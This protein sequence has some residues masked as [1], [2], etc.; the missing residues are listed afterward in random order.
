MAFEY[1]KLSK[2]QDHLESEAT[3]WLE[4]YVQEFYKVNDFSE[5]TKEQID[6]IEKAADD[7]N[8]DYYVA[9]VLRNI[10]DDWNDENGESDLL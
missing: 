7:K 2:L 3:A 6:E 8:L 1:K 10:I 5:L 9:R 4:P